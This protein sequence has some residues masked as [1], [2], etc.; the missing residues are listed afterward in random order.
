MITL[1]FHWFW[2]PAIVLSLQV[3]YTLAC[4]RG[5]WGP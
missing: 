5:G 3:F 1:H 2:I 4:F